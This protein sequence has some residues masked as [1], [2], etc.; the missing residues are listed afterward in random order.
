MK[1]Q[2][3]RLCIVVLMLVFMSEPYSV[4]AA[5]HP[6]QKELKMS[7]NTGDTFQE[8][9]EEPEEPSV[10]AAE[11]PVRITDSDAEEKTVM[12][13]WDSVNHAAEYAVF[14]W[15]NEAWAEISRTQEHSETVTLTA[16]GTKNRFKICAYDSGQKLAGES[17][18]LELLIPA[19]AKNL[20]TTAYSRTKVKLYWEAAEGAD[21]YEIYAK[22]DG[23][24]YRLAKTVKKTDARLDV[25]DKESCRFKVVPLF[26]GTLGTIAGK[27]GET[28]YQNKEFVSMDHQKYTYKEMCGDIRS[29]CKKYS[30]YVSYETIGYSEEGREIYDVILGNKK[31]DKTILVVSTLH[32]RE[33]IATV[34]C[35]KQLEYYLLNYNKTVDGKKLSDVFDSCNV[36]YVMMANPDGVTISQTKKARWKANANGVNLNRNFPYAFKKEGRKKDGSYSGKKAASE[37]ETQAIVGLTKKLNNTQTLAV[38][39]YHAMGQIVFGDYG[40]KNKKLGSDITDM[41]RI[42]RSTTGYSSAAG[43]G[44]TSNGNYREYLMYKV[45]VPS[46]TIEV[47]GISCPVPKYQ[48]ASAF[49]RNKLVV[50]REA[51]WLKKNK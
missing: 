18:E 23:K 12:L 43:Y 22:Q 37:S 26:K 36:H 27:A 16:Y 3:A 11:I 10:P 38:V 17:A 39:N 5:V 41:Y 21:A 14:F 13:D 25:K 2:P 1:K 24:K 4:S 32:A 45:K 8:Q 20:K 31:A 28:S 29:L 35:M 33:Y 48:Y 9:E 46:I 7:G 51:V 49:N 47:A 40:G 44:G 50:L 19:K 34:V 15:K 30:E 6:A 42:A